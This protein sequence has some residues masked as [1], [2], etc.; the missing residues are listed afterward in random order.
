MQNDIRVLVI[1]GGYSNEREVSIKSSKDIYAAT[2]KAGYKVDYL[3]WNGD[4]ESVKENANGYDVILPILH[5]EGGEDG[6]IQKILETINVPYLGSNS[7]SSKLCFNKQETRNLLI[8]NNVA[9]PKGELV[10]L[11]HYIDSPISKMPHVLK[12][13]N[14]GSS[15][16]TLIFKQLTNTRLPEVK[17]VFSRYKELLLEQYIDGIEI[18]VPLLDGM[19]L[20]VIEVIVPENEVFDYDNKYNGKTSELIPPIH[21]SKDIQVRAQK[22]ATNVHRIL[23]CRH[24]SRTDMIV[25]GEDLYVLEINTM[26]GMTDHSFFPQVMCHMGMNLSEFVKYLINLVTN[27]RNY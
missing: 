7:T 13:S 10:T 20:P 23:G 6:V 14:G 26:P 19:T 3:D 15:L 25:K 12:P 18:T 5:G 2:V 1:G 21:I 24:L 8:N 27:D 4:K 9:V 11:N 16:D 17:E 22:L